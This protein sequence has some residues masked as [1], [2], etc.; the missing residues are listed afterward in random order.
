MDRPVPVTGR[1]GNVQRRQTE[2][3]VD[4][5]TT[6][7]LL[8][9]PLAAMMAACGSSGSGP[10]TG[11]G[12]SGATGG[13]TGTGGGGGGG[14]GGTDGGSDGGSVSAGCPSTFP[15]AGS[16]GAAPMFCTYGDAPRPECRDQATCISGNWVLAPSQ[17]PAPA[18]TGCP[19]PAPAAGDTPACTG[20]MAGNECVY[21]ANDEECKCLAAAG[22]NGSWV[23]NHPTAPATPCPPRLPNSGASCDSSGL[24]CDYPCAGPLSSH[25]VTATCTGGAWGWAQTGC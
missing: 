8:V 14:G 25:A 4:M 21:T 11:S 9:L 24:S 2:G 20:A 22:T 3:Q 13:S 5:K 15:A 18:T 12:G 17:C 10:G 1:S 6:R 19:N 23:C 7:V 16:C